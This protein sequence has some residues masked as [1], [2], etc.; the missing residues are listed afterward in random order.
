MGS[1]VILNEVDVEYTCTIKS[2]E[3]GGV[4]GIS[5][6]LAQIVSPRIVKGDGSASAKGAFL[7]PARLESSAIP[8]LD[9]V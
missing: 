8:V 7:V 5:P 1:T 2:D 6:D 3:D 4:E 9:A